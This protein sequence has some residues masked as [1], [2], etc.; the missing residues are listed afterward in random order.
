[1]ASA[2]G[3]DRETHDPHD[4]ED[5]VVWHGERNLPPPR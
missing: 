3:L 5:D 1:V 2:H 4:D